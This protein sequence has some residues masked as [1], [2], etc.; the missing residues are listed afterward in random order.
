MNTDGTCG[1]MGRC[2]GRRTDLAIDTIVK[3]KSRD[4]ADARTTHPKRDNKSR[5]NAVVMALL[6]ASLTATSMLLLALSPPAPLDPYRSLS[7]TESRLAIDDVFNTATPFQQGAWRFIYIHHSKGREGNAV[8]LGNFD[9]L[10]DHFL[11]GNGNGC[12]DGRIQIGQR[13]EEQRQAQPKGA[14]VNSDCISICLVGDFDQQT[15]TDKQMEKL[16]QLVEAL[17]SRCRIGAAAV[18]Y[19]RSGGAG[20]VGRHFPGDEF[21]RQLAQ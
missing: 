13:W 9:G 17:Q 1:I 3:T 11:I 19:Q 5:R 14:E 10:G 16:G 20:G 18:I 2:R 12:E 8:S 4:A 15:P 6:L 7:A 21:A